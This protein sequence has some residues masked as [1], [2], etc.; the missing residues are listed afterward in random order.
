MESEREGKVFRVKDTCVK[1]TKKSKLTAEI[2]IYSPEYD[3]KVSIIV[4]LY[5]LWFILFVTFTKN[6][7]YKLFATNVS[8]PFLIII[9]LYLYLFPNHT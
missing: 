9:S 7:Y 5:Y 1:V 2:L 8:F 6:G 4:F 3:I